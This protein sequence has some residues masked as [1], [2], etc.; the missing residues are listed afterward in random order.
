M[1]LPV[2][3]NT[4]RHGAEAGK[5]VLGVAAVGESHMRYTGSAWFARNSA[6]VVAALAAVA[7]V[8]GMASDLPTPEDYSNVAKKNVATLPAGTATDVEASIVK[9]QKVV[10]GGLDQRL[11]TVY[12]WNSPETLESSVWEGNWAGFLLAPGR[13]ELLP[14]T[15]AGDRF[16]GEPI[17]Q[18][19]RGNLALLPAWVPPTLFPRAD[20]LGESSEPLIPAAMYKEPTGWQGRKR[21][22]LNN[23]VDLMTGT[24]L[25]QVTDLKLPVGGA[26]FQLTRTR[27]ALHGTTFPTI[28]S[29]NSNKFAYDATDRVWDWL[30]A[31]WMIG[32]NPI[33]LID[34]TRADVVGDNPPTCWLILDAHRSIPFQWVEG[35]NRYEAPPR[36][37]ARLTYTVTADS[38]EAREVQLQDHQPGDSVWVTPPTE[39]K[40]SLYDNA[41]VYTFVVVWEDVP[42]NTWRTGYLSETNEDVWGESSLHD[43][44]FLREKFQGS[45]PAHTPWDRSINR[46]LGIPYYALLTEIKDRNGVR[47]EINYTPFRQ[48]S[49]DSPRSDVQD[50]LQEG[51]K[52][53]QISYIQVFGADSQ[54]PAWTLVYSHRTFLGVRQAVGPDGSYH[55]AEERDSEGTL[56]SEGFFDH[57]VRR[58][59]PWDV[60]NPSTH[61]RTSVHGYSAIDRIY[62]YEGTPI[63]QSVLNQIRLQSSPWDEEQIEKS[64]SVEALNSPL[65]RL[66][67][68]GAESQLF[69]WEYA[70]RYDYHRGSPD[71]HSY[72]GYNDNIYQPFEGW[73]A[74]LVF[75]AEGFDPTVNAATAPTS[76]PMLLLTTV[77]ERKDGTVPPAPFKRRGI[78]YDRE[79]ESPIEH[80][81]SSL[82][83]PYRVNYFGGGEGAGGAAGRETLPWIDASLENAD[84][85]RLAQVVDT[86]EVSLYEILLNYRIV[87]GTMEPITDQE[88][89][90]TLSCASIRFDQ[91]RAEINESGAGSDSAPSLSALW[92]TPSSS[93]S[94]GP[95][96]RSGGSSGQG[97]TQAYWD[98][99]WATVGVISTKS[100]SSNA[101]FHAR[102]HRFIRRPIDLVGYS[103][104]RSHFAFP[105]QTHMVDSAPMASVFLSPFQWHAYRGLYPN[106]VPNDGSDA[107]LAEPPDGESLGQPR[108]V[109]VVDEFASREMMLADVVYSTGED[110]ALK[111]GMVARTVYELNPWGYL[112]RKRRWEFKDGSFQVQ[113]EGIGEEYIYSTVA[114]IAAAN[115]QVLP[116]EDHLAPTAGFLNELL[117]TEYRSLGWSVADQQSPGGGASEG[118]VEF[119]EYS[120]AVT[121]DEEQLEHF[122]WPDRVQLTAKG[123]KKGNGSESPKFY[124]HQYFYGN[125]NVPNVPTALVRFN[126]ATTS[127]L[128]SAPE[129]DANAAPDPAF[130]VEYLIDQ[131][132]NTTVLAGEV[133]SMRTRISPPLQQRP[134]GH[135][136]FPIEIECKDS[137]GQPTWSGSGL[138]R[139]P[140][141][142]GAGSPD[143][144]ETLTW[145]YHYA[146]EYGLPRAIVVDVDPPPPGSSSSYLSYDQPEAGTGLSVPISTF[147]QVNGLH[148]VSLPPRIAGEHSGAPLERLTVFGYDREGNLTD[149]IEPER[150]WARRVVTDFGLPD[151]NGE[152]LDP[153]DDMTYEYTFAGLTSYQA[154]SNSSDSGTYRCLDGGTIGIHYGKVIAGQPTETLHV[155]YLQPVP[156]TLTPQN[157]PQADGDYE[158][159]RGTKFKLDGSGRPIE[160]DNL[161]LVNG[162]L[163]K[164]GSRAINDLGEIYRV[165]DYTGNVNRWTRN[166]L[167]MRFR[168]YEGTLDT[169]WGNEGYQVIGDTEDH[170]F[171]QDYGVDFT[172]YD[173]VLKELNRFGDS[174]RDIRQPVQHLRFL[175]DHRQSW[176]HAVDDNGTL[177]SGDDTGGYHNPP[178]P[179]NLADAEDD[180]YLTKFGYDWSMRRVREDIYEIP[181]VGAQ[182]QDSDRQRTIL[183]YYD[184][185]GREAMTVVFGPLIP[186]DISTVDPTLLGPDAM[187]PS[188]DA[189]LEL[190]P[191]P[192]SITTRAFD[193]ADRVVEAREY[194]ITSPNGQQPRFTRTLAYHGFKDQQ[195][196]TLDSAAPA[197]ATYL[198]ALGRPVVIAELTTK[199]TGEWSVELSRED[200]TLNHRGQ[201]LTQV[202]WERVNSVGDTLDLTNAVPTTTWN[203]YDHSGRLTATADIGTGGASYLAPS[204]LPSGYDQ[205]D[206]PQ[207]TSSSFSVDLGAAPVGSRVTIHEYNE[208]GRIIATRHPDG[209][210]DTFAYEGS[211][212]LATTYNAA[213]TAN[214]LTRT[215]SQGR[216]DGKVTSIRAVDTLANI[217][218]PL[219]P[220]HGWMSQQFGA[221]VLDREFQIQSFDRTRPA[222]MGRTFDV[223][224]DNPAAASAYEFE[225]AYDFLGRLAQ[226]VARDGTVTRYTYDVFDELRTIEIGHLDAGQFTP[227]Y[228]AASGIA[229]ADRIGFVEFVS[230]WSVGENKEPVEVRDVIARVARNDP[231]GGPGRV[232][233]H[234]QQHFDGRGNLVREFQAIGTMVNA[235]TPCIEYEWEFVS[236]FSSLDTGFSRLVA[237][238]YPDF[239]ASGRRTVHINYGDPGT[240]T[241]K[242]NLAHIL[243]TRVGTGPIPELL[244]CDY[245]STSRRSSTYAKS[246]RM[247]AHSGAATIGFDRVDSFGDLATTAY[248]SIDAYGQTTPL[249]T[250]HY[251]R[252]ALARVVAVETSYHTAFNNTR[253]SG[254]RYD[255][256]GR[257]SESSVGPIS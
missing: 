72:D 25:I 10:T 239:F 21:E 224:P 129:F 16:H 52:K 95:Y 227:G 75:D 78:I 32:E 217:N 73:W 226:R 81:D 254:Y 134:G 26:T 204:L 91:S 139:N 184:Y 245:L 187:L 228:P 142:P 99:H 30:G 191:R 116:T 205:A 244:K 237:I 154:A 63:D 178:L 65:E 66:N 8:P 186:T 212:P 206:A 144:L 193:N 202:S 74:N 246:I 203:W 201:V 97:D 131:Y 170:D 165:F 13:V 58:H 49:I 166:Y 210:I 145:T 11:R 38:G 103:A 156:I 70:I 135:W 60:D 39:I 84:I 108:V 194:D 171:D 22:V 15:G 160:A 83:N 100:E 225:F 218:A 188:V 6:I 177:E 162:V 197:V 35:I 168:R 29:D 179:T 213:A 181:A 173:M 211:R 255:P 118:L 24:P 37:R 215:T 77:F 2:V 31:G 62:V 68:G 183:H 86:D 48:Y 89:D 147:V 112:L 115:S 19:Y 50:L 207:L 220:A 208:A 17:P 33:L 20:T 82:L 169:Y 42:K 219:T 117:L 9:E 176:A 251:H 110:G 93:D 180:A 119:Y 248:K 143:P 209:T 158:A 71:I 98:G 125:A 214:E 34:D 111:E 130:S 124:T 104:N 234:V 257:L 189:F 127:R 231:A 132:P 200:L 195:V 240:N 122:G 87:D 80:G 107:L 151:S 148:D 133:P 85:A 126:Q 256:L 79:P 44:P 146:G 153:L 57:S 243:T 36:F 40:V 56:I 199:P 252:D 12:R 128:A 235:D 64:E 102:V 61:D 90:L 101:E 120:L 232:V 47:V 59:Y 141:D 1:L 109:V 221:P 182:L 137:L 28:G 67:L 233:S 123:V 113:T 196:F 138:V 216:T 229:A 172:G 51:Y 230:T 14:T 106:N 136:Y 159:I 242:F 69:N 53:G 96:I 5:G 241:D 238:K 190:N 43:R 27:S 114:Q 23:T 150:R 7:S 55:F 249:Y 4:M 222:R 41:L 76:P 149:I 174:P 175:S 185:A 253:S 167:G 198:D 223:D 164:E 3:A 92:T 250:A 46:G 45:R 155:R 152:N 192:L 247:D 105:G 161:Q 140:L 88:R 121:D 163:R 54:Q 18:G 94:P 157:R 236:A